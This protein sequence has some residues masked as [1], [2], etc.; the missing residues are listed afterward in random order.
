MRSR[1]VFSTYGGTVPLSAVPS[2]VSRE[3]RV[4]SSDAGS[5]PESAE[6]PERA[7][8]LSQSSSSARC[9]GSVPESALA[10]RTSRRRRFRLGS[11]SAAGSVPA[12]AAAASVP[13]TTRRRSDRTDF[14]N[15]E[16]R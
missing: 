16:P 11:A 6:R 5:V 10:S 2:I 8:A 1:G 12:S 4:L 7:D 13:L 3:S 15:C 9:G 14:G